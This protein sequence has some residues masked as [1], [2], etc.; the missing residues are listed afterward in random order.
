MASVA[1]DNEKAYQYYQSVKD[2]VN[3]VCAPLLEHF[4]L[5]FAYLKFFDKHRYFFVNSYND[6]QFTR[7]R[8]TQ[9]HDDGKVFE[10]QKK[11]TIDD[12]TQHFFWPSAVP[13]QDQLLS[14]LHEANIWHGYSVIKKHQNETEIF[15]FTTTKD[16]ENIN[17]F[18]KNHSDVLEHFILHFKDKAESLI[19]ISDQSVHARLQKTDESMQDLE[20]TSEKIKKFLADTKIERI[21][22]YTESGSN[23]LSN[24]EVQCLVKECQAHVLNDMSKGADHTPNETKIHLENI[25]KKTGYS[26][27]RDLTKLVK[28]LMAHNGNLRAS[29]L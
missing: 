25:K 6:D 26:T 8:L 13:Q 28:N 29:V 3:A 4:G 21:A 15:S 18:Y 9:I 14:A 2:N 20:Q 16:R 23:F 24:D 22:V 5:R 10:Q 1:I 12:S 7:R 11:T 27:D 19:D 17:D